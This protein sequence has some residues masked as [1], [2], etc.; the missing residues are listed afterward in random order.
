VVKTKSGRLVVGCHAGNRQGWP[1]RSGQDLVIR[2]SDNHGKT[3]DT[4][5]VAAEHGN[6][7]VQSHGMVYDAEIGRLFCLYVTY[8][9]DYTAVGK[10]RGSKYTAPL[11]KELHAKGKPFQNAWLVQS[12]DGG[13][14]WSKPR[15]IGAM[16]GKFPHFGA[17]EGRQL[18]VG[19]HKGRLMLAGGKDRLTDAS[20]AVTQKRVGVWISDDHGESW[21]FSE[22]STPKEITS[23]RNVSCEARVTELP[24]GT[25][26]Y[27]VRTRNTGR[28]LATSRDGGESWT[29]TS[30]ADELVAAQ[31]NGS[32][33]TL[34]DGTGQLTNTV[35]CS[36]PRGPGRKNGVIYV[37]SDGGK[38]W[39]VFKQVIPGAFA[40]SAIVQL[41]A[42]TIGL[43]YETNH[44]KTINFLTI[45]IN[46]II[47]TGLT[48]D[49]PES[50][51]GIGRKAG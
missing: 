24:D 22:I 27:N 38:T 3:W 17:S 14:T 39:P 37:S 23:P 35:L 19:K 13:E 7:S 43:F 50:V 20:G 11:Y 31:C 26:I 32:M 49:R 41:D 25:L 44:H 42:E 51:C 1:E 46:Q 34:T 21:G 16:A 10:G 2:W 15:D 45:P 28:Q 5:V 30:K 6:Y 48:L 36:L 8:N 9:W 4:P 29:E 47:E 40:Y 33:L 12:D 18:V